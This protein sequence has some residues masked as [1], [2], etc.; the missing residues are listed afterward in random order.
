MTTYQVDPALE[1][2]TFAHASASRSIIGRAV[3]PPRRP[4]A[5]RG[6]EPGVVLWDLAHGAEL[7]FLPIG[8]AWQLM[9]EA[10]GDLLTSGSIGVW[11]WPI[12]LDL[13]RG[14]FRIGPPRQLPL[15]GGLCEIAED[16]SGRIV[17]LAD[18][19]FAYVVTPERTLHVG[20]LD[21][22]RYRRRQPGR[23][24]AGDRQSCS[25]VRRSGASAMPRRWP[26]CRSRDRTG[27]L[28][29]PDGK[30]L[31][32]MSPP[33][34]LWD[35]GTWSEARQIGGT[36][37]CFSPDGRLVVVRTRAGILRLV[38]TETGRTLARLE[39]PDLCEVAS[40]T[41]S[42]DGSRLVVTTNDGPAVHVWDLRAIGRQLTSDEP[43]LGSARVL[44]SGRKLVAWS[45]P[46]GDPSPR[47]DP[48]RAVVD[49]RRPAQGGC[50]RRSTAGSAATSMD[51]GYD[52]RFDDAGNPGRLFTRT[53]ARS[54]DPEDYSYRLRAA[55]TASALYL[56][57]EV[58]DQDVQ[59]NPLAA[60][61]PNLN[62]CIELFI[63][64]D[65]VPNDLSTLNHDGNR[66]GFQIVA[67]ADG[68]QYTL[69]SDLTNSDWKVATRRVA[70]GYIM[71]FEI[72]L[73]AIDTQD[74]P[75]TTP[76]KTGD[77]LRFNVGGS[78]V[79][80]VGGHSSNYAILWAENPA[81]SPYN[82]GEE[83][84]TVDLRLLP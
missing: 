41:F 71:E 13:G 64:G 84:W 47:P 81:V 36:G 54:K 80:A 73:S 66:E 70:G 38:E 67:D 69:A 63:D 32:T 43:S 75:G 18:H 14:E 76:A 79:D 7:A 68:H 55:H 46:C 49:D 16:R 58:R 44:Q 19:G 39:S 57:F 9:F 40:A 34:R 23:R 8:I 29:S 12:Q 6:H 31:M 83:V 53:P 22:C 17:A 61:R 20:P 3:D 21:D 45:A 65:H 5:G 28:F 25:A 56:A 10:S 74:G 30:W 50:S 60:D 77:I 33:C 15:P 52:V 62:D 4:G 2:R 72:P 82:G 51:Q 78:D 1:Y 48:T 35:V 26:S 27:V 37:L 24:M 42:P 11:R 59:V